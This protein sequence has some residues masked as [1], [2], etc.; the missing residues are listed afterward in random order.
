MV[1]ARYGPGPR[2]AMMAGV[3]VWICGAVFYYPW[4]VIGLMTMSSYWLGGFAELVGVL[5][6]AWVGGMIYKEEPA[7]A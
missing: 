1:R 2:S 6:A 5:L 7:A 4:T 3:A